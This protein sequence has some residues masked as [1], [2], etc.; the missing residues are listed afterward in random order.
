MVKRSHKVRRKGAHLAA[1]GHALVS[2]QDIMRESLGPLEEASE[3][4]VHPRY[5]ARF[6]SLFSAGSQG[7][8]E[9]TGEWAVGG[10]VRRDES[11]K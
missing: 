3:V 10:W 6:P 11:V 9:D 2:M 1:H 7:F 8:D 4:D 5:C